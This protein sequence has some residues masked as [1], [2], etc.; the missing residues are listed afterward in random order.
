MEGR[1]ITADFLELKKE[2]ERK[3]NVKI[4]F[5]IESGS[6][7]WNWESEDSDYDIRGVYIQDYLIVNE[8]KE[9]INLKIGDLDIEL[10]DLRKFLSLMLKSNPSVWEWLSSDII[11]LDNPIRE[12]LK[13]LFI[14]DFSKYSLK[15]HYIS[16]AKDNF[17]KYINCVGDKANLKKYVY[18]L[19]SL[20]CVLWIEQHNSPPPKSYKKTIDLLPKEIQ[21]FFNKI[22]EEKKKSESLVGCRNK[23]VEKFILDMIEKSFDEDKLTFDLN[24]INKIFK[25][26][27]LPIF[28][29]DNN[30]A[31][32]IFQK[33]K[34]EI[35][36]PRG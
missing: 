26:A 12:E 30:R 7:A 19:R 22:V 21:E 34:E 17:H 27:I 9:Q 36:L 5:L 18:V 31:T 2:I 16:M 8:P 20:A 23:D 6:R 35:F 1:I 24:Q 11:Y 29:I 28:K 15:K 10:W 13:D 14:S 3:N 4:L 25:R 32:E 33:L